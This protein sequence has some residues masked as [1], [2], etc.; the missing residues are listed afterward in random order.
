MKDK[1]RVRNAYAIST[2][3]VTFV[4]FLIGIAIYFAANAAKATDSIV[5]NLKVTLILDDETTDKQLAE[6]EP[7]LKEMKEVSRVVYIS[8]EDALK[9]FSEF[10]DHEIITSFDENP[11]PAAYDIYLSKNT[12]QKQI[13]KVLEATFKDK[14][15]FG[16]LLL[17]S[18]EIDQITSNLQS[19][20]V[21]I[22]IFVGILMFI[23]LVLI[24]NT[25]RMNI[26]A[27]RFVIKTM[28]LIGATAWFI[29]KPFIK[30]AFFQGFLASTFAF[31]MVIG[32]IA[33]M[34]RALPLVEIIDNY[35]VLG[36]LY[37]VISVI[38]ILLCVII[39]NM[40][41]GKHLKSGNDKLHI[42]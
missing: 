3:S 15:Y 39:T 35:K 16:E 34:K 19:F 2:M 10:I 18:T 7:K 29:R 6:I 13:K 5:E 37:G 31:M 21:L 20:R 38:G 27:K 4:L 11:L 40:S 30:A 24:N 28:M 33:A 41:V 25:I 17:Q 1:N 12:N 23:S 22:A 26:F 9:S 14:D 8:K 32:M 42:Y 36:V